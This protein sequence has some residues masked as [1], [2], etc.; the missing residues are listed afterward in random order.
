VA[1]GVGVH[2]TYEKFDPDSDLEQGDLLA[3]RPE[4]QAILKDVHPHFCNEKYLGFAIASQSCDLV[5]RKRGSK[6]KYISIAAIRS[7]KVVVPKLL[8]QVVRPIAP[9]LFPLS[10]KVAAT[11][12][13]ERLFDQN[14]QAL[15]LFYLHKDPEIEIGEPAV[16]YLRVTVA[17]LDTHYEALVKART[18]RLTSEFR[19]KFGWL[20]GNLYSR[21]AARD[22]SDTEGGRDDVG[23][24][25]DKHTREQIAGTGPTW[26]DDDLV[27]VGRAANVQFEG[28]S[29]KDVLDE[30]EARRPLPRIEQLAQI[31]AD[32]AG[33]RLVP[34][35]HQLG[36]IRQRLQTV[37]QTRIDALTG[38]ANDHAVQLR[39]VID[40]LV[41]AAV[42]EA[43][44]EPLDERLRKLRARL[45]SNTTLKK[46]VK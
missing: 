20:L 14:E 4:L 22:W 39:S 36:E 42:N 33:R 35:Q 5:R 2:W 13:L 15:G 7:L 37:G 23:E 3:P 21:A 8:A 30:L 32:E 46:L 29:H 44:G 12:F 9:G 27:E 31:A 18:G 19:G 10:G 43:R 16:V 34:N 40:A 6:A 45:V 11:Q 1:E 28:R 17:L 41:E 38:V 24:L 26:I 25:I